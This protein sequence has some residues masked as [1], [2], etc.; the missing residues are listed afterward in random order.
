MFRFLPTKEGYSYYF[1]DEKYWRVSVFIPRSQTLE[2]VTPESSYLV[3]LKFG[4]FEAMLADIPEKLG[5]TIP[6]FH[7]M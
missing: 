1:A 7:N 3:G 5:E 6:D 4:E 2:A